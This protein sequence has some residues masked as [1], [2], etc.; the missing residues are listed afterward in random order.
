M[1]HTAAMIATMQ[2][3]AGV[4]NAMFE[5]PYTSVDDLE[6]PNEAFKKFVNGKGK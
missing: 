1:D 6:S 2:S 4:K 3:V 5:N